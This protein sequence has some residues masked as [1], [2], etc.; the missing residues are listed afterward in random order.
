MKEV[1]MFYRKYKSAYADCET[2]P[3]SYNP[4]R[5]TI[6]VLIPDGRMKPSGTRGEK[7]K[8]IRFTGTEKATGLPVSIT[9]KA[10]SHA[11][12]VKRLPSDC[13]WDI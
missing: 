9:I 2:V 7:F 3:G 6:I 4:G 11:N 1:T 8:Y 13:V 12:A 5:K 10:I